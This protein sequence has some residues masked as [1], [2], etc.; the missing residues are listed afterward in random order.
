MAR[1]LTVTDG[2]AIINAMAA[3]ML[4][5]ANTLQAC[6]T[7]TFASVGESIVQYG[8][9]DILNTLALVI[10]RDLVAIRPYKAKFAL[11]N[12]LDSGV[13]SN[14][15]RKISY[16]AKDAV[17]TGH[18]NT[19]L[20][21]NLAMGFDNNTN[22]SG[23]VDRSTE[24]QY[25]QSP[26]VTWQFIF[27]GGVEWQYPWT[28][29]EDQLKMAFKDEDAWVK[30]LNGFMIS[31]AN[32]IETEKEAFS[33]LLTLNALA[34]VYDL[35]ADMPGSVVN[36]TTVCNS[37]WGTTYSTS[38]ILEQHFPEMLAVFVET[39]KTISDKMTERTVKYHWSPAKTVNGVSYYL[40]R[41]TPKSMQKLMCIS[42]FWNK[43]EAVVMPQIFH[44]E[45]LSIEN[46]E[47]VSYWQNSTDGLEYSIDVVPAIPDTSDPKAQIA[48]NRVQLDLVLACLFDTDAL[49]VD[50]EL[51]SARTTNIEARKGY[52]TTWNTF[53][54]NP[55]WDAT[56]NFVVFIMA[57]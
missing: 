41:N 23:G 11:I 15:I 35:Q 38:D 13:F 47:K 48:G 6:N 27:S 3:E 31:A 14:R 18:S 10:S 25:F 46:F 50:F 54:K 39:I 30:F 16:Y 26:A 57:D 9:E 22:P 53:R 4:G 5:S 40:P 2:Y 12:T 21:T 44:P 1:R 45:Y 37:E 43:A 51:E 32:D 36:L 20:F 8:T 55:I 24:S 17:P 28:I 49:A 19:Q 42:K 56:E 7:S 52:S 29:Y 34:G 33:R